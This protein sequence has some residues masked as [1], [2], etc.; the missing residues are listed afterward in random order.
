MDMYTLPCVTQTAS[1]EQLHSTGSSAPGS[2]TTSR[3]RREAQE[4][5]I[6]VYIWLIHIGLTENNKFCKAMMLQFKKINF[7]KSK[8]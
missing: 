1:G 6:Y 8:V 2:L 7:F 4:G 3:G 5:G